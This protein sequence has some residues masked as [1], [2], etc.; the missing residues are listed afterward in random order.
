MA[1]LNPFAL[2]DGV[3]WSGA[4]AMQWFKK[5]ADQATPANTPFTDTLGKA[6]DKVQDYHQPPFG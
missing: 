5:A 6:V 2:G 4:E 1:S 3:S